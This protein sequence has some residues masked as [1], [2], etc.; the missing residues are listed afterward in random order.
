[1]QNLSLHHYLQVLGSLGN[2]DTYDQLRTPVKTLD[3]YTK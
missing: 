2:A 3:S 1:M